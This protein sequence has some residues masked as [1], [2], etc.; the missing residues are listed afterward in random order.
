MVLPRTRVSV[1]FWLCCA[2]VSYH[3]TI[4][5]RLHDTTGLTNGCIMYTAGCQTKQLVVKPVVKPGLTTVLNKQSVRSTRLS[6]R[7]DNRLDVC[8]H[9]TATCQTGCTTSLTI[10]CIM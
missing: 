8:L 2:A 5:S 7:I 4:K 3:T 10:G 9:D 1:A 6:N